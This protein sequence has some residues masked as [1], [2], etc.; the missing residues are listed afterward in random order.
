MS[1][2]TNTPGPSA[3]Q[4]Q[5]RFEQRYPFALFDEQGQELSIAAA[6]IDQALDALVDSEQEFICVLA[7][8][9]SN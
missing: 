4:L 3:R 5:S 7:R 1:Q 6:E 8:R 2:H 9:S